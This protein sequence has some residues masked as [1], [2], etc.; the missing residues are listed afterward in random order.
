[1]ATSEGGAV[2]ED[3]AKGKAKQAE[4]TAQETWGDTKAS[5]SDALARPKGDGGDAWGSVK[6]KAG[7]AWAA[8]SER[9]AQR[10]GRQGEHDHE[11]TIGRG[12]DVS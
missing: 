9:V 2:N 12:G 5:A 11:D 4:G 3:Q 6:E 7:E 8:V 10:R 1:M